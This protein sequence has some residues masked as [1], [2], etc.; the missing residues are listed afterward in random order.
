MFSRKKKKNFDKI[1]S[2][3]KKAYYQIYKKVFP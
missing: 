1:Y 2:E 3:E